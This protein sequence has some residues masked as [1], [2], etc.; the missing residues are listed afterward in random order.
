MAS[1]LVVS[2]WV[3]RR[4]AVVP[5]LGFRGL[6][7][8]HKTLIGVVA[9]LLL[10]LA[11]VAGRRAEGKPACVV[12]VV[13]HGCRSWIASVVAR[14]VLG[15]SSLLLHGVVVDASLLLLIEVRVVATRRAV[16]SQGSSGWVAWVVASVPT[17]PIVRGV[18][19]GLEGRVFIPQD[20]LWLLLLLAIE[21]LEGHPVVEAAK[22]IHVELRGISCVAICLGSERRCWLRLSGVCLGPRG[23]DCICHGRVVFLLTF[24]VGTSTN[25]LAGQIEVNALLRSRPHCGCLVA[26]L[27]VPQVVRETDP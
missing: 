5:V 22:A 18:L 20:A 19:V 3:C 17:L 10:L 23:R 6:I 12:K 8:E 15:R 9:R 24:R 4:W 27:G 13:G 2:S 26:L 16:A 1:I 7:L 25:S 11:I 21:R 14:P